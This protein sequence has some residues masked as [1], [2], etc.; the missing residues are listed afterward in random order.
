LAPSEGLIFRT[1]DIVVLIGVE[2]EVDRLATWFT[3]KRTLNAATT[4]SA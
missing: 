4:K 3:S 2:S 1:D